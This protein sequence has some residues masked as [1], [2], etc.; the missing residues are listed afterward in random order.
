MSIVPPDFTQQVLNVIPVPNYLWRIAANTC[1]VKPWVFAETMLPAALFL[2]ARLIT[3]DLEDLITDQSRRASFIGAGSRRSKA[4]RGRRPLGD[5]QTP[6]RSQ[7]A[8]RF[9][10]SPINLIERAGF[11]MLLAGFNDDLTVAWTS[12]LARCEACTDTGESIANGPLYRE[13]VAGQQFLGSGFEGIPYPTLVQNRAGWSS[14]LQG[15]SLPF[16]TYNVIASGTVKLISLGTV[17]LTCRMRVTREFQGVPFTN[18]DDEQE[19]TLTTGQSQDFII[20]ASVHALPG[21]IATVLWQWETD[22]GGLTIIERES[23]FVVVTGQS[24]CSS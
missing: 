1:S 12:I 13:M 23:G 19:I 5:R 8:T 21:T 22:G 7:H 2:F 6:L 15:V 14:T 9:L 3:P 20:Q 16:G 24:T 17:T 10:W 11:V 18:I 4:R